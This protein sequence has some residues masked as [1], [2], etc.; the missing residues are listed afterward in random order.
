MGHSE[1]AARVKPKY[2]TRL[3]CNPQSPHAPPR[4]DRGGQIACL[5]I[6]L[7]GVCRSSLS[8]EQLQ[9]RS[10]SLTSYFKFESSRIKLVGLVG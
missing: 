4:R 5:D 10:R 1:T 9:L 6:P 8:R 2:L 3:W 7:A